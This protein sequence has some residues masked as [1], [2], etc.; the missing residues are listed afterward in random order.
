MT[1]T[2]K[3]IDNLHVSLNCLR[4]AVTCPE[5]VTSPGEPP[6][7]WAKSVGHGTNGYRLRSD[8][9][10]ISAEEHP[11]GFTVLYSTRVLDYCTSGELAYLDIQRS[12]ELETA[13][14]DASATQAEWS[15][16]A[17]LEMRW[18]TKQSRAS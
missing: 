10:A 4:W 6:C 17:L 8:M 15:S 9:P 2:E 14:R 5:P 16:L 1:L 11:D 12:P 7:S 3:E 13:R 18:N